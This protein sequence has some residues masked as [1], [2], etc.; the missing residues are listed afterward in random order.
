[1]SQYYIGQVKNPLAKDW[2]LVARGDDPVE[3][4]KKTVALAAKGE[5]MARVMRVE[6]ERW[7][8]VE[9]VKEMKL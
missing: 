5:T 2:R 9:V 1:M 7:D 6:G 3:L 4:A 8:T